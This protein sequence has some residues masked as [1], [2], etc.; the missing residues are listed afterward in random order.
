M[1]FIG[2]RVLTLEDPPGAT[3]TVGPWEWDEFQAFLKLD[4]GKPFAPGGCWD[5]MAAKIEEHPFDV[6]DVRELDWVTIVAI[7]NAWTKMVGAAPS[8]R[9]PRH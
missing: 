8:L 7:V 2:R 3:V 5:V 6:D 9:G 1:T 4:P